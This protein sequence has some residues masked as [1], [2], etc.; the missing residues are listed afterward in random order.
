MRTVHGP[1]GGEYLL[2]RASGDAVRVRDPASGEESYLPRE[3]VEVTGDAPL[4]AAAR[5]VDGD[6][7]LVVRAAGSEKHLGLLRDLEAAGPR[8]V[9]EMLDAYGECESTLAGLLA[10]LSAA[11][12]IREV[13]VDGE[14]GYALTDAAERGLAAL[15]RL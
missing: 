6:V 7:L 3:D 2:L 4:V 14:R 5:G 8:G 11:G 10:D 15:G 9:P 13:T 12:A 1:D